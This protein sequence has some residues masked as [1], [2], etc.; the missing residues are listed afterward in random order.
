MT[1]IKR[2]TER[3]LLQSLWRCTVTTTTPLSVGVLTK[4]LGTTVYSNENGYSSI[5]NNE[6]LCNN[7]EKRKSIIDGYITIEG[8][9]NDILQ[10]V[11]RRWDSQNSVYIDLLTIEDR[12]NNSVGGYDPI[13]LRPY[14]KDVILNNN[15][16]IEIWIRNTTDNTNM[17][18][19]KGSYLFIK[20]N[21]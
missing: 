12:I 1:Y 16:R 14:I 19:I 15:D 18:M 3:E 2:N 6:I 11:I 10:L 4:L 7:D 8:G 17:S 9:S 21:N 20:S 13:K 5:N